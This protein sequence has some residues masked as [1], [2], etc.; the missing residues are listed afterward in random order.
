MLVYADTSALVKLM[1]VEPESD[2]LARFASEVDILLT[3]RITQV[4]I[5][6]ASLRSTLE[7]NDV[8][9]G[10][11]S[12]LVF[13]E[14]TIDVCA[15]AAR[16][17]PPELR[18]LDAVHLATALELS[19]EVDAFLTYDTRLAAAARAHGLSVATPV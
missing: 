4:E 16:L 12:Q 19:S 8:V 3:S 9:A 6:R 1:V 14:L 7:T 11:L 10:I 2:A 18:A 13:R 17:N 5:G 15:A